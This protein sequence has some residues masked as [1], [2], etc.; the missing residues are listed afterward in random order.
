MIMEHR[1]YRSAPWSTI[2]DTTSF[3]RPDKLTD[4]GPHGR[5]RDLK[6]STELFCDPL[7]GISLFQQIHHSCAQRVHAKQDSA[8]KVEHGASVG[9]SDSADSVCKWAHVK[10]PSDKK[11]NFVA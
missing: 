10:M 7:R 2:D 11:L 5:Q 6:L 8:A 9:A 1:S 4:I 3:E